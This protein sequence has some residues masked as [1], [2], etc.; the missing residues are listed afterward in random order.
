MGS[1]KKKDEMERTLAAF[2][3]MLLYIQARSKCPDFTALKGR[4]PGKASSA[5][6]CSD[7]QISN[8]LKWPGVQIS[9]D[10]SHNLKEHVSDNVKDMNTNV[11]PHKKRKTCD[12]MVHR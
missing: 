2:Q 10:I 9:L 5:K 8:V 12:V 6:A 1:V 11:H 4:R 3:F 7:P